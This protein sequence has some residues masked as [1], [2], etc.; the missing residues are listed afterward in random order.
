LPATIFLTIRDEH[1]DLA[2]V[3]RRLLHDGAQLIRFELTATGHGAVPE[4]T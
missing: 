1:G 2:E 3:G 4:F